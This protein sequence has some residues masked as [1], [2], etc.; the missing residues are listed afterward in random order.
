MSERWQRHGAALAHMMAHQHATNLPQ[1]RG[2]ATRY[3]KLALTY[4]GG[5]VLLAI[6]LWLRAYGDTP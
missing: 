5:V 3:D 4:R 2:L 6:T 1:W